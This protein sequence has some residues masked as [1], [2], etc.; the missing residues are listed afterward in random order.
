VLNSFSCRVACGK[1]R[2][3]KRADDEDAC[4]TADLNPPRSISLYGRDAP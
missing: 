4:D 2:R 3:E 1:R